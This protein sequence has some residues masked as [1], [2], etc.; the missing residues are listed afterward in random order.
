MLNLAWVCGSGL[1]ASAQ[2]SGQNTG[3]EKSK[4][5]LHANEVLQLIERLK[6]ANL[7]D[8]LQ[9]DALPHGFADCQYP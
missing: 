8:C 1:Q 3:G 7:L 9:L 4:F 5:G 2:G 6:Q